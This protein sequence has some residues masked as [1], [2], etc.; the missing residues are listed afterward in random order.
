ML[1]LAFLLHK[2]AQQGDDT[3]RRFLGEKMTA[4][5]EFTY[6]VICEFRLPVLE[7]F[8]TKRNVLVTP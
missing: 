5:C 4:I 6:L 3:L 2:G 7:L 1:L 8:C